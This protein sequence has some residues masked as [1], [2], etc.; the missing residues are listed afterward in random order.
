MAFSGVDGLAHSLGAVAE[1]A[2]GGLGQAAAFQGGT[3][4]TVGSSGH[5][6]LRSSRLDSNGY[7]AWREPSSSRCLAR[8][9]SQKGFEL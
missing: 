7:K 2:L 4:G 3:A 9:G 6:F 1:Q 5:G 8:A